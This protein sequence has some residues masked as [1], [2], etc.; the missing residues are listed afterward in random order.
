MASGAHRIE[1]GFGDDEMIDK[2]DIKRGGD[3]DKTVS[4]RDIERTRAA[5]TEG[6][7]CATINPCAP[8]DNALPN[9][10]RILRV[11]EARRPSPICVSAM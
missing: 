8:T 9:R 5:I 10:S 3:I 6:W 2:L 4:R 11:R 7:L 1:S